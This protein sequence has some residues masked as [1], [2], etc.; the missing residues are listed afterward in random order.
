MVLVDIDWI[1]SGVDFDATGDIDTVEG[2]EAISQHL[3]RVLQ[4]ALRTR[5]GSFDNASIEVTRS[6]LND[7]LAAFQ[8][9][10]YVDSYRIQNITRTDN[11]LR[12]ELLVDGERIIVPIDSIAQ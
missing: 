9:A 4:T 12:V 10:G 1:N 2:A 6:R 7:R 8:R 11:T 5:G 3:A